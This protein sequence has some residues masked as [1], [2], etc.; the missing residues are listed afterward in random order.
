[1]EKQVQSEANSA[2]AAIISVSL[3]NFRAMEVLIIDCLL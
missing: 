1:M 3:D 2:K